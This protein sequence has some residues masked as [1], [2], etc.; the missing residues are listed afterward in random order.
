[1]DEMF[2]QNVQTIYFDFDKSD[3]RPDQ[4]P[5]VEADA[6]WL[7]DHRGLKFRIEGHC[8]ERG[9]E[10]YNLALASFCLE[11][12]KTAVGGGFQAGQARRFSWSTE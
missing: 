6:S 8:D 5:R 4:V 7:K 3:I 2:R 12:A 10:E 11:T 1:M 9:S